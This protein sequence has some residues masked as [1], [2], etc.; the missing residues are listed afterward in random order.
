MDNIGLAI[1]A[2][3]ASRHHVESALLH[4][5]VA[6]EPAARAALTEPVRRATAVT[7]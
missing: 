5:P 2:I 3:R 6:R 1:L 4:A 7:F